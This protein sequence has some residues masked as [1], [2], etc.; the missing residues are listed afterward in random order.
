MESGPQQQLPQQPQ[1]SRMQIQL[2]KPVL[3]YG[4]LALIGLIFVYYNSL[5][6]LQQTL[7][8]NDWAK[9]NEAVYDGEYYRLFTAMF[10][11]L[12]LS[13]IAFN[14]LAL[15]IFGRDV[16]GLFGHTR[17]LVIYLLGG[18]TGSVASL[19]YT[20]APSIGASGAI[21]AL[22]S[23]LG[24]HFYQHR[25]L[26]GPY[27]S[28]RVRQMVVLAFINILFGLSPGT[29][30]DNAAHVGGLIGGF[31]LAWFIS[32]EF[33]RQPRVLPSN[34]IVIMDTNPL[35]RWFFVPIVYSTVLILTVVYAQSVLG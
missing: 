9:V 25:Q 1:P 16:E 33:Q 11:H 8:V 30:I 32:P 10:L 29:R 31:I 21:F 17:F 27:A 2:Y 12:D 35:E 26:Y 20:D 34:Q 4:L 28:I 19:I 7:L 24:V 23:A 3:T 15:Y 5:N 18:L 22:F 14:G 6:P 13:H